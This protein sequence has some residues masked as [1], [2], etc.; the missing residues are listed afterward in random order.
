M[1]RMGTVSVALAV[2]AATSPCVGDMDDLK[3]LAGS[4]EGPMWGGVFRA[5]YSTPE[6]GKVLSISELVKE[7]RISYT[8]FERFEMRDGKVILTPYPAGNAADSF[9]L[10]E[11]DKKGCKAIFENPKKDFPTRILYQR[12]SDTKLEITLSDPHGGS[13]KIEKFDLKRVE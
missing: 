13:K 2:V 7:G 3:W 9:D 10:V 12:V 6:G 11:L 5:Y 8:E 1:K 4:W